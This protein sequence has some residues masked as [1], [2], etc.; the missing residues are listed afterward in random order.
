M[1]VSCS[2]DSKISEESCLRAITPG[3][4]VNSTWFGKTKRMRDR[5]KSF[6]DAFQYAG[7]PEIALN[8]ARRVTKTG[9]HILIMVWGQPDGME[10]ASVLAALRNLHPPRPSG[11]P[12]PFALSDETALRAFAANAGLNPL[13]VFD[14]SSIRRYPDLSVALR[15]LC[16][17]A[18]AVRAV[19]NSNK[20]AVAKAYTDALEPFCQSDGSYSIG[21]T[22]RCLVARAWRIYNERHGAITPS[23]ILPFIIGHVRPY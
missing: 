23:V 1:Q 3:T 17:A 6:D 11:A 14:I 22:F 18:N 12:G 7:N 16:S 21:V 8:E 20:A 10:F 4:G 2:L 5:R 13:E 19:E 9:A 15:G